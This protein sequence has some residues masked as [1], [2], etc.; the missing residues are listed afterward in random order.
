MATKVNK[1]SDKL[2]KINE[3]YTVY[4]YDNGFMFDAS[5]EKR[6]GEYVSTKIMVATVEE[7]CVLVKEAAEMEKC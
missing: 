1:L 6:D 5:G 2:F 3:S 7:L 4:R